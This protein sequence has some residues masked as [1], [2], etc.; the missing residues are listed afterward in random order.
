MADV[1]QPGDVILLQG[2][3]GAGKTTFAR[4]F[5]RGTTWLTCSSSPRLNQLRFDSSP[6]TT[7][8]PMDAILM[9]SLLYATSTIQLLLRYVVSLF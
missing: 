3:V 5:I 9:E 8:K 6:F 4:T 2:E 7:P 1:A